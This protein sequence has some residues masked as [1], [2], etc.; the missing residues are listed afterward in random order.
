MDR[1]QSV[2]CRKR[3][4]YRTVSIDKEVIGIGD[5]RNSKVRYRILAIVETLEAGKVSVW[6]LL[7]ATHSPPAL[8]TAS[9]WASSPLL[10]PSPVIVPH[11]LV[12]TPPGDT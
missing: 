4:K 2:R 3:S 10:A 9:N 7:E 1:E 11:R 6:V 8:S 5:R 12:T